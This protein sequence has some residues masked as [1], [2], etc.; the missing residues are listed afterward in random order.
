MVE[1]VALS[2][3]RLDEIHVKLS[4]GMTVIVNKAS[5][6]RF[7][8]FIIEKGVAQLEALC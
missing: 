5:T 4:D 2:S 3:E 8:E 1:V 6:M 7:Y